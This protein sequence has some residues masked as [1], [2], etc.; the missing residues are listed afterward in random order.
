MKWGST[1]TTHAWPSFKHGDEEY[2]FKLI[3]LRTRFKC[4]EHLQEILGLEVALLREQNAGEQ[5]VLSSPHLNHQT[6]TL[7]RRR[8][9]PE[10]NLGLLWDGQAP[11]EHLNSQKTNRPRGTRRIKIKREVVPGVLQRK[12]VLGHVVQKGTSIH[13]SH[14]WHIKLTLSEP[15][16]P[17]P[18]Y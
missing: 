15:F 16:W 5:R 4:L 7:F 12:V 13:Y 6:E 18:Q 8:E 9:T 1:P 2:N 14:Q 17:L 10:Q 11:E 3:L